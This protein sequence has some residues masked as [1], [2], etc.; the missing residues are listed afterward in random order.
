MYFRRI[1]NDVIPQRYRQTVT[2]GR[3]DER[4]AVTT[5]KQFSLVD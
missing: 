2:D 3:T 5:Q 4:F 1:P